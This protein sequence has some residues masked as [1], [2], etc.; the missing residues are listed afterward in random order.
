MVYTI[1]S[2]EFDYLTLYPPLLTI[3]CSAIRA[4][5]PADSAAA[6]A[7]KQSAIQQLILDDEWIVEF[8]FK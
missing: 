8:V 4:H 6:E 1:V 5:G 7:G 2:G 3:D